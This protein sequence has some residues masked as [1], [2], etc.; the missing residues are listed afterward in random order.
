MRLTTRP[1]RLLVSIKHDGVSVA[2]APPTR[3]I[4]LR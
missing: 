4:T 2:D 1:H 3:R